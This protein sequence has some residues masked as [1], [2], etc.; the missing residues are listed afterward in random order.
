[1]I[2][3]NYR[4]DDTEVSA[5]DLATALIRR[6]SKKAVFFDQ[7]MPGGT[8]WRAEIARKLEESTLLLCV[9]GRK[10]EIILE[11][12]TESAERTKPA[13]LD[14][15]LYEIRTAIDLQ[16]PIIPLLIDRPEPAKSLL[17]AHKLDPIVDR[18]YRHISFSTPSS[19]YKG[20]QW[21][22]QDLESIGGSKLKPK[23]RNLN[24]IQNYNI[25]IL[26]DKE[27]RVKFPMSSKHVTLSWEIPSLDEG[28]RKEQFDG[29][30]N[31]VLVKLVY[32]YRDLTEAYTV[33]EK[34]Y[35][36]LESDE[37]YR[38]D[39]KTLGQLLRTAK[40]TLNQLKDSFLTTPNGLRNIQ[41]IE[42]HMIHWHDCLAPIQRYL[43]DPDYA[44]NCIAFRMIERLRYWMSEA[45]TKISELLLPFALFH[46]PRTGVSK[47][48]HLLGK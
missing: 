44:R 29:W 47:C 34:C 37:R 13:E 14:Y 12:R 5:A 7:N 17:S 10:W 36:T 16:K 41:L 19:I 43:E 46:N 32:A 40:N 20:Y 21:L 15:V 42:A 1:M 48:P 28:S 24:P 3:I 22:Y 27:V 2:F 45:I 4:R 8:E 33:S 26:T 31:H 9:M 30:W 11:K 35:A 39:M 38:A 18:N 6:Y 23:V 25:K